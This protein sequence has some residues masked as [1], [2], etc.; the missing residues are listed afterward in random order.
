MRGFRGNNGS[1]FV[2]LAKIL[3]DLNAGMIPYT[4]YGK[5]N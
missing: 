5:A 2:N 3:L 1:I 4:P